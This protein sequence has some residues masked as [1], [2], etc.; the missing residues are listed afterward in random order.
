MTA[1]K[2]S[3][4]C[5]CTV[6]E[7]ESVV[8]VQSAK[9]RQNLSGTFGAVGDH[10]FSQVTF[11]SRI[12]KVMASTSTAADSPIGGVVEL[13]HMVRRHTSRRYWRLFDSVDVNTG[14]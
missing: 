14:H 2:R 1:V 13:C 6:T 9:G 3:E 11:R 12:S 7:G 5:V 10:V 4:C 8:A